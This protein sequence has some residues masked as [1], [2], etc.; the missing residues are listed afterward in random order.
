MYGNVDT[1]IIQHT[2]HF[3]YSHICMHLCVCFFLIGFLN[4]GHCCYCMLDF[5]L[6]V[7]YTCDTTAKVI[8]VCLKYFREDK[9]QLQ[10]GFPGSSDAKESTCCQYR[11]PGFDPWVRKIP[12]KRKW[13]P[14][15][16]FLPGQFHGQRAWWVTV[17]GVAKSWT[18]LKD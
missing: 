8:P 11:R 1:L 18:R 2:F 13:Q 10:Q 6:K 17:H 7:I 9:R 15:P 3:M 16:D 14:T 12:W 5:S 4:S